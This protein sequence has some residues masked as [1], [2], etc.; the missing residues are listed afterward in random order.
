MTKQQAQSKTTTTIQIQIQ[1]SIC[2]QLSVV[3]VNEQS[4]PKRRRGETGLA[5]CCSRLA[6]QTNQLWTSRTLTKEGK[7][8]ALQRK[9]Q[10]N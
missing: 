3:L 10:Y 8:N 4:T 1:R 9:L 6:S 2:F 5:S 7:K